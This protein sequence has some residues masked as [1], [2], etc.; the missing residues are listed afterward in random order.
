M[1]HINSLQFKN[2]DV[3]INILNYLNYID[4]EYKY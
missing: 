3:N 1:P 4:I 2:I